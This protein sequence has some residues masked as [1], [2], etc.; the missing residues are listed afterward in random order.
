MSPRSL[1]ASRRQFSML[2]AAP[3]VMLG[4]SACGSLPTKPVRAAVYDFGPGAL[5]ADALTQPVGLPL[6]ALADV[7]TSGGAIDKLAVLYRLGYADAQQLRP[8]AQAHWSMPAA[9]LVQQRLR[10]MLG[11]QHAVVPAGEGAAMTRVQGKLP[12]VLQVELEEFSHFFASPTSSFGLLRL[13]ATLIENT[14]MGVKVLAQRQVVSRQPASTPD[15]PGGVRALAAATD[16][17]VHALAVWL[18]PIEAAR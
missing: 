9:A 15:A 8:Y 1:M 3:V 14:P 7:E 17:A 18:A 16:A 2:L 4:L 13:R 6:L 12:L 10:Q 5:N 11:Q